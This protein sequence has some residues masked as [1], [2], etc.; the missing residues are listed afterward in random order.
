MSQLFGV[1][2]AGV[3]KDVMSFVRCITAP[4]LAH[5]EHGGGRTERLPH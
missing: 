5:N 4:S 1:I 3:H 2:L